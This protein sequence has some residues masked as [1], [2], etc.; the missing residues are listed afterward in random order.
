VKKK[1]NDGR[2]SF[3]LT[4]AA[5][6]IRLPRVPAGMVWNTCDRCDCTSAAPGEKHFVDRVTGYE[7][8]KDQRRSMEAGFDYYMAKPIDFAELQ[9]ILAERLGP[10]T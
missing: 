6:L 1:Q 3:K 9:K 4:T 7:Q 2:V 5:L 8:V 10:K